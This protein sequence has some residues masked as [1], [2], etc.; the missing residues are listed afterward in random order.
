MSASPAAIEVVTD[1][2]LTEPRIET[3]SLDVRT[4]GTVTVP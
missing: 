3:R 4:H 2:A 1:G